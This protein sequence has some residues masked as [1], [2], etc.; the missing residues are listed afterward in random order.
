MWQLPGPL[1]EQK[2]ICL[3]ILDIFGQFRP[4]LW[5]G[6]HFVIWN[7]LLNHTNL[8]TNATADV[9]VPCRDRK[10]LF[11]LLW[12]FFGQIRAAS[13]VGEPLCDLETPSWTRKTL[14]TY[15][16]VMKIDWSIANITELSGPLSEQKVIWFCDFGCFLPNW[17]AFC[18]WG[19]YFWSESDNFEAILDVFLSNS[20]RLCSRGAIVWS[21]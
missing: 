10:W 11:W 21:R 13:V 20:G 4:L 1:P 9:Q 5:S 7:L 6:S 3:V 14:H 16:H 18:R 17:A 15:Y 12:A 19:A 8:N 2:V